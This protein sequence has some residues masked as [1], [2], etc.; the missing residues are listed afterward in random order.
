MSKFS[1]ETRSFCAVRVALE[2]DPFFAQ[3]KCLYVNSNNARE[4]R[5]LTPL[6]LLM[7]PSTKSKPA[8]S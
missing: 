6:M 8:K 2:E 3:R 5:A 4:T 7:A 1:L